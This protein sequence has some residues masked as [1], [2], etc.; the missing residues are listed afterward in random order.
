MLWFQIAQLFYVQRILLESLL[1]DCILA[2]LDFGTPAF[3]TCAEQLEWSCLRYFWSLFF[4]R[5]KD[6]RKLKLNSTCTVKSISED[7][8]D[9]ALF[10]PTN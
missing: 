9:Q 4:P 7:K 5:N 6:Y 3:L 8:G 1:D 10:H 2:L